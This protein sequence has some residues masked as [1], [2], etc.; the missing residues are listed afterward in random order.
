MFI[1]EIGQDKRMKLN[2]GCGFDKREGWINTDREIDLNK[3]PYPWKS[4]SADE[5]MMNDVLEHLLFPTKVM[6]ECWRILKPNGKLHIKVPWYRSVCATGDCDHF[7][8]F[9]DFSLNKFTPEDT[10]HN[11]ETKARFRIIKTEYIKNSHLP[12]RLIPIKYR[13]WVFNLCLD[14]VYEMEAVKE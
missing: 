13:N 2:L 5:M 10:L 7:H 1:K 9:N 14:I 11:Y 12:F 3:F 4:N 8:L 6:E